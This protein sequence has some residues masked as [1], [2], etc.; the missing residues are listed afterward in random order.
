MHWKMYT[1]ERIQEHLAANT[2]FMQL[3]TGNIVTHS[4]S[5]PSSVAGLETCI[6]SQIMTIIH[7]SWQ[8]H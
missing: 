1:R 5:E 6:Q 3:N 2:I 8:Y 4:L 7:I